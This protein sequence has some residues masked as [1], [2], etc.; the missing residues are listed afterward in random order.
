M[1]PHQ[2][3]AAITYAY[4]AFYA[5]VATPTQLH[6]VDLADKALNE[7]DQIRDMTDPANRLKLRAL[8][9]KMDRNFMCDSDLGEALVHA[10]TYDTGESHA[11]LLKIV[12]FLA[13][14]PVPL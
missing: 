9:V 2:K 11:P 14:P 3:M 7:V 12:E 4:Q 13:T 8:A 1:H 5:G 10:Y 6:Q